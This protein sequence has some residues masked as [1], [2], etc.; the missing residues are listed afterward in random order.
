MDEWNEYKLIIPLFTINSFVQY[1]TWYAPGKKTGSVRPIY[2]SI[3]PRTCYLYGT[4]TYSHTTPSSK[5]KKYLLLS[6]CD[7]VY[8]ESP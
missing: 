6:I 5:K 8:V 1:R 4:G 3:S 2:L 7:F